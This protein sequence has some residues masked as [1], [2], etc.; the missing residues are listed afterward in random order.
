[1]PAL[2]P[3]TRYRYGTRTPTTRRAHAQQSRAWRRSLSDAEWTPALR[4]ALLEAIQRH[5]QVKPAAAELGLPEQAVYGRMR[6]DTDLAAQ[7]EQELDRSCRAQVHDVTGY[8]A[9]GRCSSCRAAKA[10]ERAG[11]PRT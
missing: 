10:A 7:V 5:G 1:M 11:V 9:G 8:R 6:W 4:A 3:T 2:R